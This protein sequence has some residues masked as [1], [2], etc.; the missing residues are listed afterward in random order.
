VSRI[1]IE[2]AGVSYRYPD[3][4]R[5]LDEVSISV[6][7]GERVAV[8]GPNGAGKTTLAMHLNG[9]YRAESGTIE[10]SG[11]RLENRTLP[12]IRRRVGLVF[13]DSND[14]LFMP[15]VRD[16]VGFGPANLGLE[17]PVLQ[18]RVDSAMDS[19]GVR[20]LAGRAPHHLSSGEKRKVAIATV[21]AMDPEVLVLDEPSAGLDPANR[22]ELIDLLA[23][24]EITQLVITH[25]LPLA[26]D[27]CPRA[28]IMD[29]GRVVAAGATGDLLADTQLLAGHRLEMPYPMAD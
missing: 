29:A 19:V 9:L 5:A 4:K 14:Q 12:E 3:G 8:L 20:S 15:T 2:V 24:V 26:L 27:L 18:N 22:R 25:D 11:L 17:G 13:Q 28:V 10:I 6:D 16:D 1:A 7:E 23:G 21:L